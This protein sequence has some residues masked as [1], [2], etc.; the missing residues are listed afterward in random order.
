MYSRQENKS[1]HSTRAACDAC[2]VSS[3]VITE[4]LIRAGI[5]SM[6]TLLTQ[7][8]HR[9]LRHGHRMTDPKNLLHSELASGKRGPKIPFLHFKEVCKREMKALDVTSIEGNSSP[10]TGAFG[11]RG[12]AAS[13][14]GV[15]PNDGELQTREER[16]GRTK[17]QPYRTHPAVAAA[18]TDC[19]V[20]VG[21]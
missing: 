20:R 8:R 13:S 4:V 15:R 10:T 9:R 19:Y 2:W 16:G 21:L 5:P 6:F 7:R 17:Q 3:G 14:R 12:L 18:A 11:G 1:T